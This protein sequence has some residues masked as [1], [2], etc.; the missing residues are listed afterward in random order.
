M[1]KKIL[2]FIL[3]LT[4]IS[5]SLFGQVTI[6]QTKNF[7]GNPGYSKNLVYN[8]FDPTLGTLTSIRIIFN[9]N[10]T[11]GY[12]SVDND[13]A[14]PATTTVELGATGRLSSSDVPL[15]NASFQPIGDNVTV[16]TGETFN[17]AAENGDGQGNVD[18]NPP[19]GATHTGGTDTG[20]T[21]DFVNSAV[22]ANYSGTGTYTIDMIASSIID[23]GGVG[24]V[25]GSFGPPVV[26]GDVT[27][28]YTYTPFSSDLSLSKTVSNSTPDAGDD[29]TF[30]IT[31][32]NN[33]PDD[34]VGV[35]VEDIL[36]SGLTYKSDNS[37]GAYNSST[38]IWAVGNLANGSN[39][40]LQITATVT[41]TGTIVNTAQ[42]SASTN[43]DPDSTP[44][45]N[46]PSEDDQD[47]ETIT[48]PALVDLELDKSVDNSSPNYKDNVVFTITV[49]NTSTYDNA[50]GVQVKDILPAGL[51][52]LSSSGDGT[53][54][55]STGVWTVGTVDRNNGSRTMHIT[56]RMDATGSVE[57]FAQISACNEN[58]SDS[59][60][61]N[62][63]SGE[64][65]D[66]KVTVTAAQ[67]ADL[68]L[69]KT[70][71]NSSPN[72]NENVTF[73]ITVTNDGPDNTAN[74][75]VKDIL[76]GGLGYQSDNS[77]GS[78]NSTTGI[79][80][81]GNLASGASA[82]IQITAKVNATGSITNTAQVNA[83]DLYDPD[84]TPGNNISSEDDQDS[85]TITVP[86]IIDL[87]LQKTVDNAT[88][89]IQ[90]NVVFTITVTNDGPDNASGIEVKDVLPS[91][92][93][94]VS[95][96]SGGAYNSSTG[97]WTVGSLASSSNTS[98][99]IT[100][101]V[102][103][104]GTIENTAQV[105]SCY[106]NDTDSTPGNNVPSEDDQ[107]SA[108]ITVPASAD[109][110]LTK[111]VNNS[112]PHLGDDITF[113][114]TVTNDGPDQATNV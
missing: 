54:N 93:A 73:T 92:L 22:F 95:D 33:G 59:T 58:D 19:D 113:T 13:G 45:N 82:S 41:G 2:L 64:D 23:F 57:N 18:P 55:S 106:D 103:G 11:G 65:D 51:T 99:Q 75:T 109:L 110:R 30:T 17:L 87:S 63:D 67:S 60:P 24:G 98:I 101:R 50:T 34:A 70:V 38:G 90:D 42:V 74:V 53:Y 80:T 111:T 49:T 85:E 6:S 89:N 100:A 25:E 108:S 9:L 4:G 62:G 31:L 15:I 12:L 40:T 20:N 79:W 91:G 68:R 46:V 72:L 81:V 14:D 102:T 52:Y 112:S 28:V 1:N 78:Y 43:N 48:V 107:D 37:G 21:S 61:D 84:S 83:S 29:I 105:Q 71:N 104:T 77:G 94:Y 96:N 5:S 86:R 76:P 97:I 35:A 10:T 88:P 8:K 26:G 7:T 39:T 32:T 69:E 56:A 44:G 66:D 114:I 47:S 36:P 27:I 16:S 3:L